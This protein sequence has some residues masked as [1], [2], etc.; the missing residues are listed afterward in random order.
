[1]NLVMELGKIANALAK[2]L[3]AK[4]GF[5]KVTKVKLEI[6]QQ[7]INGVLAEKIKKG[8]K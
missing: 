7:I 4:K 1:M 2:L 3:K 8:G 5:D 6:A